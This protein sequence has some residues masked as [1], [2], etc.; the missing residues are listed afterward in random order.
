MANFF[1]IWSLSITLRLMFSSHVVACFLHFQFDDKTFQFYFRWIHEHVFLHIEFV[2]SQIIFCI[3]QELRMQIHIPTY[4]H[5]M[6]YITNLKKATRLCIKYLWHLQHFYF[7]TL[8]F[9][10]MLSIRR[11]IK[12]NN[13]HPQ[14]GC[15]TIINLPCY[16]I[17]ILVFMHLTT[18]CKGQFAN[19]NVYYQK[20]RKSCA[21]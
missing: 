19:G 20:A 3:L 16:L 1:W 9:G 12:Y 17:N 7:C 8:K 13:D 6:I 15:K 4:V 21:I 11:T 2:R 5:E 18:D 10:Q 14:T